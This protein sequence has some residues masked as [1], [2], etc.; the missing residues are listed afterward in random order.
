MIGYG[1]ISK[2]S[3]DSII[4]L[5]KRNSHPLLISDKTNISHQNSEFVCV[6]SVEQVVFAKFASRM[7]NNSRRI[8]PDPPDFNYYS[9]G[10]C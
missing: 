7:R 3:V 6:I 10:K 9:D 4:G 1:L 8:S 2:L 5:S